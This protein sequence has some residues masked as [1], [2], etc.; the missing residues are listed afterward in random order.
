MFLISVLYGQVEGC[1]ETRGTRRGTYTSRIASSVQSYDGSLTME[2]FYP[3]DAQGEYEDEPWVQ[4]YYY[5]GTGF[6]GNTVFRGSLERFLEMCRKEF[7]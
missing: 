7:E 4:V 2:M 6:Y 5:N 3:L 1:A